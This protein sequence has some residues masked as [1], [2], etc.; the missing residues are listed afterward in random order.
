M[1]QSSATPFFKNSCQLPRRS[2]KH[3]PIV[4]PNHSLQNINPAELIDR[5]SN[6]GVKAPVGLSAEE[7]HQLLLKSPKLGSPELESP[8]LESPNW[9]SP[10]ILSGR[11]EIFDFTK[12][13][14]P[15]RKLRVPYG[16]GRYGEDRVGMYNAEFFRAGLE[17]RTIHVGVDLGAAAGT[18]VFAPAD[19]EVHAT[20]Y[21]G[22]EGDYG[23]TV[24]L[25]IDLAGYPLPLFVLYGHLS[26]TTL[27]NVQAHDKLSPGDLVG[28]LGEK[29]ENGGWNPH[30]HI[31]L[32][33]LEPI[34]I[35]L[36]GA[37]TAS[38]FNLAAVIFPD[39]SRS[40]QV[41]AGGWPLASALT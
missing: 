2:R 38:D 31:Q 23:G 37:V 22:R 4:K 6:L 16:W 36:P 34:E 20:D 41:A 9:V 17:P 12:G 3:R 35:D 25:R 40:L 28:W 33:W 21:R 13:Y 27:E 15:N 11:Y 30:L 29:H 5:L 32:S 19:C 14:D 18:S 10:V 26:R 1:T 7:L 39:P 24:I 8:E